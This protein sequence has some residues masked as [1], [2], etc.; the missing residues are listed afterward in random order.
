MHSIFTILNRYKF[1]IIFAWLFMLIELTV[2][3]ISPLI[4]AKIIDEGIIGKDMNEV[5]IWGSVLIGLSL[6]AFASGITNSFLAARVSQGF[7]FDIR[8]ALFHKVQYLSYD[9]L[10]YFPTSSLIIRLT[11]DVTQ[12]QNTVFMSLR[13]AL[14]A[15]LLVIFGT[16]MA[17]F[18]SIKLSLPLIISIPFLVAFLIWMMRK[19]FHLFQLVQKQLDKVNNVMRENLLAIR[20]IKAF[21]RKSFESKRFTNVNEQLMGQTM[22]ALRF[23]E[24]GAPTLLFF[25]NLTIIFV[26]W[27]GG[28]E[29][30]NANIEAG[31]VVAIVNYGTRITG[32]LSMLTWIIMAFSRAKASANRVH[33]LLEMEEEK[34]NGKKMSIT[35]GTIDFHNV[36]FQY[37]QSEI[38]ILKDISFSIRGGKTVAIIGATGA[39]KTS[40]IQLILRLFEPTK[41]EIHID[42]YKLQNIP[43]PS[44]RQ[45][46]GYVPQETFLFT[47]TIKENIAFGNRNA[48]MKDIETAAKAAQIHDAIIQFPNGYHTIVGQRGINLSGGQKQRLTIARALVRKPKILLLDDCTSAL[49]LQTEKNLLRSIEDFQCT[50]FMI[51]QK[52]ST[53]IN[54]DFILLLDEGRLIAKGTHDELLESSI[55]YRKIVK[56][57]AK[58][59]G[60]IVNE[61]DA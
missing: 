37:S 2:E 58:K 46:I 56:S 44:L 47:G 16:V 45:Q 48:S 13:I 9:K 61:T 35:K 42:G 8:K 24:V 18:V 27:F 10:N 14:R 31:K 3:L 51:T 25:M 55:L 49:D 34:T 53:A 7:G 43:L 21:S 41:G 40:L 12:I 29:I 52:I 11:N 57:Q 54:A 38:S 19:G 15:P 22:K 4:M 60:L 32:A 26:L 36:S 30:G 33:E 17:M 5:I 6:L 39:G 50:I 28:Q 23:I 1:I 20:L 59:G